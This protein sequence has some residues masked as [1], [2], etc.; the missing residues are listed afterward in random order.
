MNRG[1]RSTTSAHEN[2]GRPKRS[3]AKSSKALA[4]HLGLFDRFTSPLHDPLGTRFLCE[5][6][7]TQAMSNPG[8]GFGRSASSAATTSNRSPAR[9]NRISSDARLVMA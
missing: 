3:V 4:S 8:L 7:E 9:Q 6:E 5:S 1:A 2:V